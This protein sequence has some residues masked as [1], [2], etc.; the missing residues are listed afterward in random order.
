MRATTASAFPGELAQDARSKPNV[1]PQLWIAFIWSVI[2]ASPRFRATSI[3][4]LVALAIR[5][6]A[7]WFIAN[8]NACLSCHARGV[9]SKATLLGAAL[10]VALACVRPSNAGA[11]EAKAAA[12][13]PRGPSQTARPKLYLS[14]PRTCFD[15]YLRQELN[16]FDFARDPELADFT[17][18]IARQPA[19]NGGERFSVTLVPRVPKLGRAAPP[20]RT[21]LA[22]PGAAALTSRQQLLQTILRELQLALADTPHEKA[23]MLKLPNRDGS[24]LGAL[25]DPWNYWVA[26]PEVRGEGEGGSGYYFMDLTGSLTLR[27]I[28]ESSK[29]RLRGAYLRRF[30]SYRLEDG[31]RVYGDVHGWEA[32]AV[33]ARSVGKR[34]ALGG[35]FTARG[36]QFENLRAHLNG[37]P[38]LEYNLFPYAQNASEQIRFA[39]QIGAWANWYNEINQPGLMHEVRPY[40]ALSVIADVNQAFGSVQWVGQINSFLD[41]PRLFR[42]STGVLLGLRLLEGLAINLEGQAALVRDQISLRQRPVT[43]LELLLWT[44]QQ[45]TDYTFQLKFGVSYTFGSVH[46]TIVNPR[47][48]RVDL[49]EE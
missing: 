8:S 24:A 37:G 17:L 20:S 45:Q 3:G 25:A 6:G 31:T 5:T 23:F 46:N 33:Y 30:T 22:A 27:R 28:T 13:D 18:V 11:D 36:N 4:F 15:L 14:C 19:G 40:H 43:D 41:A 32:R 47:F 49:Q 16:Y 38:L 2:E 1:I 29:L 35:T 21:F 10:C 42:L 44:A 34:W 7:R 48:A 12:P 39:Y 26:T 9:V